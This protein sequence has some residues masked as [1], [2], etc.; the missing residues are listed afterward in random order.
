[1]QPIKPTLP[2]TIATT[3]RNEREELVQDF[4]DRINPSREA[5]HLKPLTAARFNKLVEG[6]K[7]NLYWLWS[8]CEK[9]DN[10]SKMWQIKR[11]KEKNNI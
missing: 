9:A 1:M 3:A 5:M 6:T 2:K 4:L 11:S 7:S 8:V 10:F